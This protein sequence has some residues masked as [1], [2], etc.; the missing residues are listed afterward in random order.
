MDVQRQISQIVYLRYFY[1]IFIEFVKL[2]WFILN[3]DWYSNK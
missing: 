3:Y 2:I 1:F